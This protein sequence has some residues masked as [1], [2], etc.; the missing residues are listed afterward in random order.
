MGVAR[1]LC[2]AG[3]VQ[4]A[5]VRESLPLQPWGRQ[6]RAEGIQKSGASKVKE[7]HLSEEQ[8]GLAGRHGHR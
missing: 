6:T 4:V 1:G 3:E 2:Q 5:R 7:I 8:P